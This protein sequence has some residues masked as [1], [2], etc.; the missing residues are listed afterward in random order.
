MASGGGF[1]AFSKPYGFP[2]VGARGKD[3]MAG[4]RGFARGEQEWSLLSRTQQY[5]INIISVFQC[6]F[7]P[8]LM[9]CYINA[10]TSF[11]IRYTRPHLMYLLVAVGLALVLVTGVYAWG[12]LVKRVRSE[13]HEPSWLIFLFV[14]LLVGWAN[15]LVCGNIN[16]WHNMQ[17]YYD[18]TSLSEYAGV[19]PE[20]SKGTQLMDAGR[21]HFV[22]GSALDLRR[23]MGFRNLDTYCVAPITVNGMPLDSYDFWAVGLDCC[24]GNAADFQCG[25][26]DNPLALGG[27]RLL[28]DDKRGFFRLAVQQA[29]A[30]YNIKSSHPLFLYLGEDPTQE[31]VFFREEGFKYYFIGMVAHFWWQMLCV[32][33][34]VMGFAKV[35]R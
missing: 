9:F 17:P 7:L 1:S 6:L 15:G 34:A 16:Y 13:L 20:T 22:N 18:Y 25:E 23:S 27:L 21:V 3:E 31:M 28:D 11:S 30:A 26:Y 19:D 12:V 14:T 5:R 24:S 33:M 10:V 4:V 29:E 32:S 8:W 35:M 2:V